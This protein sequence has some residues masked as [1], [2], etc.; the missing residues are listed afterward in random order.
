MSR[1]IEQL[2]ESILADILSNVVDLQN[3]INQLPEQLDKSLTKFA[4]ALEIAEKTFNSMKE[5]NENL[6]RSQSIASVNGIK[7]DIE[8]EILRITTLNQ[9]NNKKGNIAS[10]I[11]MAAFSLIF[12]FIGVFAGTMLYKAEKTQLEKDSMTLK[13]QDKAINAL[14]PDIKRQ[15]AVEYSKQL[16]SL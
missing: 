7:A 8:K 14:P 1:T 3:C 9:V 16:N 10:F 6:L 4:D 2:K 15:I 11:K 13:I 5:E 12:G